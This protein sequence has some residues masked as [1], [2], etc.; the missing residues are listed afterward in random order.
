[1]KQRKTEDV[2]QMLADLLANLA[3]HEDTS[4][5]VRSVSRAHLL[6]VEM[7]VDIR[8]ELHVLQHRLGD[9]NDE[10]RKRLPNRE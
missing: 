2:Q 4:S 8:D 1:M 10:L 9:I 7:L 5:Y 3:Q 6:G